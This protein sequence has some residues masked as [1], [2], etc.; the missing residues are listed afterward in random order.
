MVA[1][2]VL[3]IIG[4]LAIFIGPI[5]IDHQPYFDMGCGIILGGVAI[6]LASCFMED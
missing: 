5:Y 6:L 1:K 2:D 4:F 3:R